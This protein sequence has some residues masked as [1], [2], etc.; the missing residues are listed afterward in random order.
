MK[1]FVRPKPTPLDA[2]FEWIAKDNPRAAVDTIR[3][4]RAKLE[5][6]AVTGSCGEIGRRGRD[7]GT[8]ELVVG[9]YIIVYEVNKSR[10]ELVVLGIFH[11]AQ[12][13]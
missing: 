10:D 11:G 8:R 2:V 4:I 1:V 3:R 12:N 5:L 13:R 7:S 6:L 9:P